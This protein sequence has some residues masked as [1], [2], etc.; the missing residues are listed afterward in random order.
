M[1]RPFSLTYALVLA[2][3]VWLISSS[4][5]ADQPPSDLVLDFVSEAEAGEEIAVAAHLV[6]PAGNPISGE[7][8]SFTAELSFLNNTGEADIGSAVTDSTGLAMMLY[9]PRTEGELAISAAFEG[10]AVYAPSRSSQVLR[11]L[12]GP[13]LYQEAT[14]LRIP[15]ANIWMVS[16]ILAIVWGLY[17]FVMLLVLRI[18]RIGI[19]EHRSSDDASSS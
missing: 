13:E 5:S 15:G 8:I 16:T 10:N 3:S 14:P 4:L 6:D 19:D 1:V 12:P 11:V 9:A 17:C 18:T 7:R 2:T